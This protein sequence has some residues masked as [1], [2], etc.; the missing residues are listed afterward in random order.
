MIRLFRYFKP[1]LGSIIL[2]LAL[3][4]LQ[5]NADLALPD[6][7]SR[8]VNTGIQQNGIADAVPQAIGG[9]SMEKLALFL[10][11]EGKAAVLSAYKAT[12]PGAPGYQDLLKSYPKAEGET[13]YTL[14]KIDDRTRKDIDGLLATPLA[15]LAFLQQASAS[16]AAASSTAAAPGAPA[17]GA[18]NPAKAGAMAQGMGMDLSRIPPGMDL[19]SVLKMLPEGQRTTILDSIKAKVAGIDPSL[20][21]QMGIQAVKSEYERIGLDVSRLQTVYILKTGGLM[22]LLTLV[23]VMAAVIVGF[24]GA[25]TAAGFARDLRANFFRKVE[26]FSFA[27]FDKFSTASLITRSTNDITQMQ[28]VTVMG[29]RMFIYAPII[30]I[31]GVIRATG[32]ASSMWWIIA[33]A[34]GIILSVIIVV[35]TIALP[36]FKSIQNLI[37]KLNL[38]VRENLSGMMVIRAFSM[39]GQEEKRFDRANRDLT[40]TMLFINR[41][42]VIMMPLMMMIMNLV[43]LLIIWTGAHEVAN[44]QIHVGDM[45]AFMQYAMQIFFSFIMLSMMFIILPRASV[46]GGRIADVLETEPSIVDPEVP[47]SLDKGSSGEVEF[48]DVGFRYPGATEAVLHGIS[49]TARPGQTTAIIG[50]TG[51]G[52]STLVSLIPRFYDVTEGSIL[53]GGKDVRKLAQKDLR[54]LIGYVPQKV[55]L[56]SGTIESNLHYADEKAS[57]ED[58]SLALDISQAKEFVDAKPE[59]INLEISQG[60]GNVSGGQRQRLSIARALVKKAPINIFDDSFSALD[61][62]TDTKLRQALKKQLGKSVV[63]L[64][65]QRVAAIKQADQILVLDEGRLVGIGTHAYLMESCEVYRDIALSQLKQEELA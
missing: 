28:M 14:G 24:L 58:M 21:S 59:G 22:L 6:Y 43:S 26:S 56:F 60:G 49:F 52:K 46:S 48:R 61:F 18:S 2:V 63:L 54:S 39:Q 10:S 36:K 50:T 20:S 17:A 55:S 33:L 19:F 23:S 5:A 41:V 57:A 1:Y 45:M 51:S 8:I 38:V 64:V 12:E 4:F 37:D 3:L 62:K 32:K 35:F 34:V 53:V 9:R 44:S 65:T 29:L 15:T 7:M 47:E 16:S 42:M 13:I 31:G 27:E 40:G 25:R 11:P 30:G